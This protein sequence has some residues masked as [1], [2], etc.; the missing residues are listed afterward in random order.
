MVWYQPTKKRNKFIKRKGKK[1]QKAKGLTQK[2]RTEVRKIADATI[3]DV[4]EEKYMNTQIF[5][6]IPHGANTGAGNRIGVLAFSTSLS[7]NAGATLKYGFNSSGVEQDIK[8]LKMLRPFVS[9]TG[10]SQTDNYAIEG[11]ECMPRSAKNDWRFVRDVGKN[12]MS[13][14]LSDWNTPT[15][16]Q[17]PTQLA[18][19]LPVVCRMIRVVPTLSQANVTCDPAHDL[20]L[21]RT[22]NAV[23]IDSPT[24]NDNEVL[25]FRLNRRRY[26]VLQDSKFVIQN[27]VSVSFQRSVVHPSLDSS[28]TAAMIQPVISNSN[29]NCEK[30][31]S[32]Y[33]QLT[34]KKNAPVFYDSPDVSTLEAPSTGHRREFIFLHFVYQ[35]AEAFLNDHSTAS[36]TFPSDLIVSCIPTVKFTDV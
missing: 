23:G 5:N 12:I 34:Q 2:Q 33:H 11:R 1:P 13:A 27:G 29:K 30:Y 9:S 14:E 32:T 15:V 4:A 16:A 8:E 21:D 24:L 20:F 35:G 6:E 10:N 22:N 18:S 28:V 36:P 3:H 31:F 19:N 25:L 17:M 26:T 7:S